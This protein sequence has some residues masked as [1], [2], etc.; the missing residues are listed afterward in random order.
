MR[1]P[2]GGCLNRATGGP[3]GGPGVPGTPYREHLDQSKLTHLVTPRGR[4]MTGSAFAMDVALTL[5][6]NLFGEGVRG[7]GVR[8]WAG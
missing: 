7:G 8:D 3:A 5:K 1:G 4:W 2:M 6:P